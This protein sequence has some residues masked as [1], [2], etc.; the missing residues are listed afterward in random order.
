MSKTRLG[1][2]KSRV[3]GSCLSRCSDLGLPFDLGPLPLLS[4][5]LISCREVRILDAFCLSMKVEDISGLGRALSPNPPFSRCLR[6]GDLYLLVPKREGAGACSEVCFRVTQS[7]E[8]ELPNR[9]TWRASQ[10]GSGPAPFICLLSAASA[11]APILIVSASWDSPD[12]GA[13]AP[14]SFLIGLSL[15]DPHSLALVQEQASF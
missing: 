1:Q 3:A 14:C 2:Q 8:W 6:V 13:R 12:G 5:A 9:W 11:P 4:G 7:G 15:G 10:I